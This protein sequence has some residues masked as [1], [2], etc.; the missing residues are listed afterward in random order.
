M[1]ILVHLLRLLPSYHRKTFVEKIFHV[2]SQH[3]FCPTIPS[4]KVSLVVILS[5][6]Y[7]NLF[8]FFVNSILI[9]V[10][11]TYCIVKPTFHGCN[12]SIFDR[13][14]RKCSMFRNA[15]FYR[16][17]PIIEVLL[18]YFCR[19]LILDLILFFFDTN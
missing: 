18:I 19:I 16:F 12:Y 7:W 10:Y 2:W 9:L 5:S 3:C 15:N 8:L 6:D 1:V 13:I 4:D 17:H 11:Y 14:R